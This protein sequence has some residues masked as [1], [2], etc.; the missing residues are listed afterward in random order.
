MRAH[1]GGFHASKECCIEPNKLQGQGASAIWQRAE[2]FDHLHGWGREMTIGRM[3][4]AGRWQAGGRWPCPAGAGLINGKNARCNHGTNCRRRIH[5]CRTAPYNTS[6]VVRSK[7]Q[8]G[9][10][11]EFGLLSC[12]CHVWVEPSLF[13]DGTATITRKIRLETQGLTLLSPSPP[14]HRHDPLLVFWGGDGGTAWP[15][16]PRAGTLKSFTGTL[17]RALFG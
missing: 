11:Q 2:S 8:S 16:W 6:A 14:T 12:H 9:P 4:V 13:P 10:S 3:Q 17:G 5:A 7:P 1:P 15:R